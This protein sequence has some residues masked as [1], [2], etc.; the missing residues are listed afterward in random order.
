MAVC[1]FADQSRR[2]DAAY[3][4]SYTS[5]PW[6][7]VLHTTETTGLPGYDGGA[8]APHFTVVPGLAAKTVVVY[9]HFDTSRPSRALANTSIPG[10]TNRE[11]CIQIELVG[12]SGWIYSVAPK[13][14]ALFWPEAPEWA[15][16]GLARLM[17]WIEAAH[18]MP[19]VSTPRPWVPWNGP[20]VRMSAA[21]WDTFTG[22]CGHQH[23]PENDHTDPGALP[24]ARLLAHPAAAVSP[25]EDDMPAPSDIWTALIPAP[26]DDGQ[27]APELARAQDILRATHTLAEHAA[28]RGTATE[29]LARQAVALLTEIRDRLAQS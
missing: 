26:N 16:A 18:G 20:R 29:V 25:E 2:Y 13:S 22:W 8:K 6:R 10:E 12:T 23:V 1:P 3:P 14:P 27:G 4:M 9:Q 7:G 17:R 28:Q 24:I 15:L 21:E 19:S 11:Q 5:G